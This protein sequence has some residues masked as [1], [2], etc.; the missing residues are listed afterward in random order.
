VEA[1][2]GASGFS[3]FNRRHVSLIFVIMMNFLSISSLRTYVGVT[4]GLFTVV[5]GDS[6]M[7]YRATKMRMH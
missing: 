6:S 1:E 5:N 2:P 3:S 4:F 7:L